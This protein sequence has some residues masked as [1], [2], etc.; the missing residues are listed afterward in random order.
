MDQSFFDIVLDTEVD[1]VR[2]SGPDSA[3]VTYLDGSVGYIGRYHGRWHFADD[4]GCLAINGG[5]ALTGREC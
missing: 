3:E 4:R 1:Y 2:F 5:S